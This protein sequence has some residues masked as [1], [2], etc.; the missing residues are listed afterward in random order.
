MNCKNASELE[1]I[2]FA[3]GED[4]RLLIETL[5]TLEITDQGV[6]AR[7]KTGHS[8]SFASFAEG[9]W[10]RYGVRLELRRTQDDLNHLIYIHLGDVKR[11]KD[12]E[13]KGE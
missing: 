3:A 4:V 9:I 12:R 6:V 11:E 10:D 5:S 7:G 8:L 1:S 13:E 2:A